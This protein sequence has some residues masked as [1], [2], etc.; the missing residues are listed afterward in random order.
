MDD[1]GEYFCRVL[2]ACNKVQFVSEAKVYYRTSGPNSLSYIGHSDRKKVAL[3]CSLELHIQYIRS[4]EDSP[5][6]RAACV[7]YLQN[8]VY[9]FYPDRPDLMKHV[10]R[11]AEC[12]GGQLVRPTLSWKAVWTS[13]LVGR[14]RAKRA[15]VLLAQMK[16]SLARLWDMF[17]FQVDGRRLKQKMARS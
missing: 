3:L 2:L 7:T 17:L 9:F 6:V 1:D 16:W 11:I 14:Q 4:L 13:I 5:R 15:Q 10:E 8:W 12:L